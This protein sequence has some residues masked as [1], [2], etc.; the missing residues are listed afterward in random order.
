MLAGRETL[1][2]DEDR[3]TGRLAGRV[4]VVTGG[5]SGIGEAVTRRFA[6]EGARVLI[7]DVDVERG[8]RLAKAVPDVEFYATDVSRPAECEAMVEEARARF[9]RLDILVNNAFWSAAHRVH[10]IEDEAWRKTLDVTLDAVF[11]GTRAILPFFL[12][13]GHGAIVNTAS[14][15]GLG[16]DDGMSA[17]N[18][19]KAA[20]INLT[21][22]TAL[23]TAHRGIRVNCVC[24]GLIATP[25][26]E[27]AFL[28][29]AASRQRIGDQLPMGR[30]GD[31]AEMANV[32]LFLASDEASYVTGAALVAD[33]GTSIRSGVPD[34]FVR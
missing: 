5:A 22:T 4:A 16:G 30:L 13:Q 24:P 33:G 27:R 1:M 19:A 20:V 12:E 9:D 17:Y 29:D 8:E 11:Y 3:G 7:A 32:F 25:A 21:R 31:P 2:G 28:R 23:E 18:A 14:I 15:S 34:L 10:K 6:R 26:V